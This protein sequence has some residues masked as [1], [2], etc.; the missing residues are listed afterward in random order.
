[1]LDMMLIY[2]RNRRILLL[3]LIVLPLVFIAIGN[4]N[5]PFLS[6]ISIS[7]G[8]VFLFDNFSFSMTLPIS[9]K[10][11]VKGNYLAYL[12]LVI[13]TISYLLAILFLAKRYFHLETD[14]SFSLLGVLYSLD[15]LA[16]FSLYIPISIRKQRQYLK[17]IVNLFPA[18]GFTLIL[19]I[20]SF[21][22]Y[23]DALNIIYH[24][25]LTIITVGLFF[26]IGYSNS[27]KNI[28]LIDF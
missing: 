5:L 21:A 27:L 12:V 9:R 24:V 1:M 10:D 25:V 17:R 11:I 26:F 28:E 7:S 6:F 22:D 20:Y 16:V 23:I 4:P 8:F 15:I 2:F 14:G 19:I 18:I 13:T 3:S